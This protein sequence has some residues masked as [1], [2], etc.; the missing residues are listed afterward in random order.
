MS[1]DESEHVATLD[2]LVLTVLIDIILCGF[3]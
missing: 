3:C 1:R 2:M